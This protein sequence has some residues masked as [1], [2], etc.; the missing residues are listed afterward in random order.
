MTR[1]KE[2]GTLLHQKSAISLF[3]KKGVITKGLGIG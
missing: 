3:P 1:R 2:N